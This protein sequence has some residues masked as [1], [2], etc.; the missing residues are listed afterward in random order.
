MSL[1]S[2]PPAAP[3]PPEPLRCR[4]CGGW[5]ERGFGCFR[6]AQGRWY[7]GEHQSLDPDSP[8]HV[9]APRPGLLVC[10]AA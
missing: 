10:E 2:P 7:C 8:D 6:G 4:V 9:P 1:A 5:A 3:S